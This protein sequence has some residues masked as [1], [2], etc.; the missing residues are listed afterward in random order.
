[1]TMFKYAL[2]V[3]G[4]VAMMA[5]AAPAPAVAGDAW[6]IDVLNTDPPFDMDQKKLIPDTYTSIETSE[7]TKKWHICFLLPHAKNAY[8]IAQLYGAVEE[9]KRTGIKLNILSAG[10]YK[11][12]P[13]QIGQLEDC[14]T[15][16]ADAIILVTTSPTGLNEA[17]AAARD[18]GVVVIDHG[19][20]VTSDRISGRVLVSYERVGITVGK[21]LAD[22]HPKGSGKV[23]LLYLAGPPGATYIEFLKT[24][25]Y[26]GIEGSDIEVVKDLYG[27]SNKAVQMKLVEDGLVT[28]PDLAYIAGGGPGIEGAVDIFAERG[29]DNIG[30]ISTFVTPE[31]EK[32]VRAGEAMGVVTD[33]AVLQP[34]IAIDMTIKILEGK[35]TVLDTAPDSM[36]LDASNI[37]TYDKSST[38][39]PEGWKP[40]WSVN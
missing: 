37:N 5:L 15:R 22:K 31:V 30:L 1:M 33:L 10:G 20:G 8:W 19:N 39:A 18:K 7:I 32:H 27:A 16:G 35:Q 21:Y 26:K 34:R 29:I 6:T 14:V 2:G 24:G 25:F 3:L 4:L 11:F 12:L 40:V 23:K 13:K 36:M 17:I 28:Y 38:L 9:A